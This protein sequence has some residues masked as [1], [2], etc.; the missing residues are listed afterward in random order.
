MLRR[1]DYLIS[2]DPDHP[3]FMVV[4]GA[5]ASQAAGPAR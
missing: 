1:G 5:P 3:R 2:T 4:E